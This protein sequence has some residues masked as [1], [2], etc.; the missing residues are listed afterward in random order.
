MVENGKKKYVKVLKWWSKT[1]DLWVLTVD[2]H[3]GWEDV[4]GVAS[5]AEARLP[6]V[7]VSSVHPSYH[8]YRAVKFETNDV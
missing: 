1:P 5:A 3:S 7:Y 6:W 8:L 2:F 4:S